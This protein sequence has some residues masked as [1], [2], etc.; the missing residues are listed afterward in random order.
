MIIIA[1]HRKFPF[2]SSPSYLSI[3][4]RMSSQGKSKAKIALAIHVTLSIHVI[5]NTHVLIA[6]AGWLPMLIITNHF[7]DSKF[8]I[9]YTLNLYTGSF[10]NGG[11]LCTG[12]ILFTHKRCIKTER[13][14]PSRLPN[15]S[16][17]ALWNDT[18]IRNMLFHPTVKACCQ[19]IDIYAFHVLFLFLRKHFLRSRLLVR[20]VK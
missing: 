12:S 17:S 13:N 18:L 1:L 8:R 11:A 6:P 5:Y 7:I 14:Y 4:Q 15:S 16:L 9:Y 19:L 2:S 20:K 3:V 10:A